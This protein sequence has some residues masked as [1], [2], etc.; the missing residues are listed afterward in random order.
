M[1]DDAAR[2]RLRFSIGDRA[3]ILYGKS[4]HFFDKLLT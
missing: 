2:D 1:R 3:Y 4:G